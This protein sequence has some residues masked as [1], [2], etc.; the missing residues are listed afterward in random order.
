MFS[1]FFC[2]WNLGFYLQIITFCFFNSYFCGVACLCQHRQVL[3]IRP[4]KWRSAVCAHTSS[5]MLYLSV[6]QM[7]GY[8]TF[9]LMCCVCNSLNSCRP[10]RSQHNRLGCI[11]LTAGWWNWLLFLVN[12]CFI[13]CYI[14]FSAQL[15]RGYHQSSIQLNTAL[16]WMKILHTQ[17]RSFSWRIKSGTFHAVC[18]A[19]SRQQQTEKR[20]SAY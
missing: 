8:N 16:R 7:I 15:P 9:Q 14:L 17:L 10:Q 12:Y 20:G 1:M 18:H 5:H 3:E 11:Y 2:E 19:R 6:A 4:M 13:V